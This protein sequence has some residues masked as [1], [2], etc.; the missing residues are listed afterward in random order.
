M[1]SDCLSYVMICLCIGVAYDCVSGSGEQTERDALTNGDTQNQVKHR[2]EKYFFV[3]FNF[4]FFLSQ[5]I[6][7]LGGGDRQRAHNISSPM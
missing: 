5:C 6:F 2:R 3:S 7:I 4:F 1:N